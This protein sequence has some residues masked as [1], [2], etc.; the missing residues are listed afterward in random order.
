[1]IHH[2]ECARV[3]VGGRGG[4][5]P[6][7]H[8]CMILLDRVSL[9]LPESMV[10]AVTRCNHDVHCTARCHTNQLSAGKHGNKTSK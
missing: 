5:T 7:T 3:L 10:S 2:L 1:M 8:G 4:W 9:H 6:N